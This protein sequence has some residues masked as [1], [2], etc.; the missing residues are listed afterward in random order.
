MKKIV[1]IVF[2]LCSIISCTSDDKITKNNNDPNSPDNPNR[3]YNMDFV[4]GIEFINGA[5]ANIFDPQN[6]IIN[7]NDLDVDVY[8]VNGYENA[9]PY[10]IDYEYG[11]SIYF[12]NRTKSDNTE[13]YVLV[14]TEYL[15]KSQEEFN[16]VKE[17]D[18][19]LKYKITF[20]DNTVYEV[21][22]EGALKPNSTVDYYPTKVYINDE[23][24]WQQPQGT[25]N[26]SINYLTIVK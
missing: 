10:P 16:V 15:N 12:Y 13:T 22:V 20:P 5:G 19:G 2:S 23:L 3:R 25:Y 26:G 14:L 18:G 21:K 7:E 1:F 11:E 6:P 17:R 8:G 24:K 9:F 4:L